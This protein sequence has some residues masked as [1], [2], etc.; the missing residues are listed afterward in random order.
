[1]DK[2]EEVLGA[3]GETASNL[4]HPPLLMQTLCDNG[5]QSRIQEETAQSMFDRLSRLFEESDVTNN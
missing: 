1:M 2:D 3:S 5:F 4:V